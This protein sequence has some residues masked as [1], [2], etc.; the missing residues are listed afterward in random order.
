MSSLAGVLLGIQQMYS[1]PGCVVERVA[2][3]VGRSTVIR[4][5]A[6]SDQARCPTCRTVSRAPHSTYA[7]CLADLPSL[8]RRIRL[9]LDVRAPHPPAGGAAQRAVAIEVGAE[10]GARLTAQFA[11]PVSPDTL[12]RLVRRASLSTRR[13]PRALD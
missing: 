7:H 3:E 1:I 4:V 10:S 9:E 6:V 5:R 11:M 12:L 2:G 13:T 8:G